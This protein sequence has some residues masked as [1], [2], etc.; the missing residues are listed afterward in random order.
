M[1]KA[2]FH[3]HIGGQAVIEGVM[4]R[5]KDKWVVSV[6][7]PDNQI[8]VVE[9]SVPDWGKRY[10]F[11]KLFLIRGSLALVE[12]L[13]LALQA[14]SISVDKSS[15]E[16]VNLSGWQMALTMIVGFVLALAIFFAFPVWLAKFFESWLG[17]IKIASSASKTILSN[18]VEGVYRV[19]LFVGY[20]FIISRLKDI[21]RVFEYHGA[22]HKTIHAYEAGRV[23]TP[24]TIKE[25]STE[26]V[27]CGTSFLLMVMII[28]ILVFTFLGRPSSILIRIAS[29][30]I[31]LPIVAGLAYEIIK[32]AGRHEQ[33]KLVN[34]IMKPGLALQRLTTRE[35]SSDQIEVAICSLKRLLA[36]EGNSDKGMK[37]ESEARGKA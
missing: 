4:L 34:I 14:L 12:S 1:S 28:S 20:L 32:Y 31:V 27:R 22:E 5:G 19:A 9:R 35:P 21:R 29:R 26:H 3:T 8:V 10:P 33:S 7:Q 17:G 16:E 37:K 36:I 11:L 15:E 24:T 18:L 6:R 25:F 13:T 23:L 30:L 2:K